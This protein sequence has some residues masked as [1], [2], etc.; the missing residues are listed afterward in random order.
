MT[1]EGVLGCAA[2]SSR[3]S[4]DKAANIK[5]LRLYQVEA[6]GIEPA[7]NSDGTQDL[8]CNC[9]EGKAGR[10]VN[11]LHLGCPDWLRLSSLDT[12]LQSVVL[13]WDKLSE[14]IRRAI[15]ALIESQK[16]GRTQQ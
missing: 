14:P 11:T 6:A 12:D 2:K 5:G 1:G 15:L 4:N 8:Y 13:A 16:E 7:R 3:A 10:A 9:V